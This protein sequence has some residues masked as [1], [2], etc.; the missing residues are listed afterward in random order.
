[1]FIILLLN[2]TF[3]PSVKIN[4]L[5]KLEKWVRRYF[6]DEI[7]I[8]ENLYLQ[9]TSKLDNLSFAYLN[10]FNKSIKISSTFYNKKN[11]SSEKDKID[12]LMNL[13]KVNTGISFTSLM[14]I[15]G[16]LVY[17]ITVGER[18]VVVL[19][20]DNLSITQVIQTIE[21]LKRELFDFIYM[22]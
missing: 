4:S 8:L 22:L 19:L 11:K 7:P 21:E 3:N 16:L 2:E 14:R 1:L 20:P 6:E 18:K 15:R 13:F 10:G 9:K 5:I 12:L 17:F